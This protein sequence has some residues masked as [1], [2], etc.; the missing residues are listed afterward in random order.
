MESL[1][2]QLER[3]P[4]GFAGTEAEPPGKHLFGI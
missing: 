1:L 2:V 4:P 3:D